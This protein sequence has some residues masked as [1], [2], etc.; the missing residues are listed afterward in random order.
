MYR[1]NWLWVIPAL[2][3]TAPILM[4]MVIRA[5]DRTID[6]IGE[7]LFKLSPLVFAAITIAL[8]PRRSRWAGGLI[9]LGYL[10]YMGYLDSA[11]ALRVL[12]YVDQGSSGFAQFYQFTLLVNSFT[13]LF[14]L[15]AYRMGGADTVSVLKA[16]LAGVVIVISGLNDLSFWAMAPW[17]GSRPDTLSWASHIGVFFGH[18]PTVAQAVLFA[19]VHLA[20]AGVILALPVHRWLARPAPDGQKAHEGGSNRRT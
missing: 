9:V 6:N 4:I 11:Y 13:V 15:F 14:A 1:R 18:P 3:G 8:F 17:A 12:T 19:A 10:C 7:L 2:L 5:P 20:L 16:G